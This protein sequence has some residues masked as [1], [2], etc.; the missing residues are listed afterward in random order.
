M[1]VTIVMGPW[2][3]IPPVRGGAMPK[4]WYGLAQEFVSLGHRVSILA[5]KYPGQLDEET[6][7]KLRIVRT[8]G[9]A[10]GASLARDLAKDLAYAVNLLPRLPS[11][12][13][14]V[15]NDFWVPALAPTLRRSA[16]ATVVCAARLP[17]G[18]YRLYGGVASVV[19]ISSA[20]RS[21]VVGEQP[22]L[23]SR[24]LVIPLPVDNQQFRPSA[25]A[26]RSRE[27]TLLYVGRVHPE[28]GIDLLLRSFAMVARRFP[29]WRV[30]VVGP[31]AEADGGG[32]ERFAQRVRRLAEGLDVEFRGPVFDTAVLAAEYR[33]ADLFCYPS[34]ADR[35]EAFGLA[36][37]EAMASGVAP[38]VSALECF[39]D[40]VRDGENGWI[41]DH[42]AAKPEGRL[43]DT[44][45]LAMDDDSARI[46]LG[47]RAYVDAAAFTYS[48]VAK[49]YL[50][51]FDRILAR[52]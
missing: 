1:N 9:F 37:L 44:L 18:Q 26:G 12:D 16:G 17:R 29:G 40:F 5:R 50:T 35:G 39:R 49:Q 46:R 33:N 31:E 36:P 21:A 3:P 45:A 28:K 13:V 19:A 2:L 4:V 34:L 10:Q 27:R 7:G 47:Q 24:T 8:R 43:A 41:F 11:A 48:A 20:V 52:R 25:N 22:R 15:S 32:G 23:A 30:R 6:E 51:E 14:L 42:R 38:I